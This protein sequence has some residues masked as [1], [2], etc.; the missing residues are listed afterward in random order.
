MRLSNFIAKVILIS[1]ML[2]FS[3]TFARSEIN[4]SYIGPSE[5][6][7]NYS[8]NA[9][10]EGD[11]GVKLMAIKTSD[12]SETKL[13]PE[14][15]PYGPLTFSG[16][17]R[18]GDLE[19]NA[20]YCYELRVVYRLPGDST[21]LERVVET[22]SMSLN[23]SMD[24]TLLFDEAINADTLGIAPLISNGVT[25]P[26]GKTLALEG[27]TTVTGSSIT[28]EGQIALS[29]Q[30]N[31]EGIWL[32]IKAPHSFPKINKAKLSFDTAADGS[33]IASGSDITISPHRR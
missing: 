6:H 17:L 32:N 23:D 22:K 19:R 27:Q 24:G 12:E 28:V 31:T 15:A 14:G 13:D 26:D 1:A 11:L 4:I 3:A 29:A 7:L 25:V 30:C 21:E 33:S 20:K 16:V 5:T 8:Y 18:H 10:E 9:T 2:L